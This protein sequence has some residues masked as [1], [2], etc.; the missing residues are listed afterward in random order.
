MLRAAFRSALSAWRQAARLAGLA[1]AG[2]VD[3]RHLALA[4][5]LRLRAMPPGAQDLAVQPRLLLDVPSRIFDGSIR[6]AHHALRAEILD[7]R[8]AG[9]ARQSAA[10]PALPVAPSVRALS[11]RAL[12][13]KPGSGAWMTMAPPAVSA[14]ATCPT[15]MSTPSSER[16]PASTSQ[17]TAACHLPASFPAAA[18]FGASSG[19]GA[20][21]EPSNSKP[22][23]HWDVDPV[24][25]DKDVVGDGEERCRPAAVCASA[26]RFRQ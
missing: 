13:A 2:R 7:A 9:P 21:S 12:E 26:W 10:R 20:A 3:L 6:R 23:D 19:W 5:E 18:L 8:R 22:A 25:S 14:N 1:G 4:G 16:S 11:L 15:F 24:S 17:R